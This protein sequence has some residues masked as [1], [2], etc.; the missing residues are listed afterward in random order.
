MP[1]LA[2]TAPLIRSYEEGD[3]GV[4]TTPT[5]CGPSSLIRPRPRAEVD[6]HSQSAVVS[7]VRHQV[8]QSR[9]ILSRPGLP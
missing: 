5:G 9:R 6:E 3:E 1:D 2:T 8:H 4:A 7:C